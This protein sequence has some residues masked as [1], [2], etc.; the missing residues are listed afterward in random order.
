M[1]KSPHR[2]A[3]AV[4]VEHRDY[5]PGDDPRRIDWRVYARNDRHVIKH[6]EQ[7]TQLCATLVLDR[8]GSMSYGPEHRGQSKAE[9]AATLL[10][11]TALI[12]LK[13]GDAVAACAIDGS[14]RQQIPARRRPGHLQDLLVLLSKPAPEGAPTK[15]SVALREVA[16]MART[17]G[18]VV[19]ASDLLD[20]ED[21][22]LEGLSLL[23]AR[24]HD[25]I[26][27]HVLHGDE[28]TLP[29]SDPV[30]FEGL[31][32]EPGLTTDPSRLRADY[33]AQMRRFLDTSRVQCSAR[34]VRYT[35]ARTDHP[36]ERVLARALGRPR[37]GRW[38]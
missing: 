29:F 26:V 33:L 7:E 21:A 4:F 16:E 5:R 25:V 10:A 37:G 28:V 14:L 11:A 20:F 30:Q 35:L 23:R 19:F 3:S 31:E 8:S 18:V 12:L 13:Q 17:R 38:V 6:F 2:G 36:P 32:Q 15:L 9:Y 24:G 22:A 34:G 1:H 27:L